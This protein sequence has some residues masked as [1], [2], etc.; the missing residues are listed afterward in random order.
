MFMH[1]NDWLGRQIEGITHVIGALLFGR[2]AVVDVMGDEENGEG[3]VINEDAFL[4]HMLKKYVSEGKINEAEN[5]LFE[6]IEND[7]S[8]VKLR[9]AL[10]FYDRLGKLSDEYLHEH[11]FSRREILD[12]L[13]S[14]KNMYEPNGGT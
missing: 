5:L 7:R 3:I 11:N 8:G 6:S 1:E 13:M 14:V 2:D 4:S 9:I 12:G 10:G